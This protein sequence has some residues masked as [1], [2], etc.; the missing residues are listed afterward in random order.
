MAAFA[1][2]ESRHSVQ[3]D[4]IDEA[5]MRRG[6][7]VKRK[8]GS[9]GSQLRP[10]RPLREQLTLCSATNN[11]FSLHFDC[12]F[13]PIHFEL[14]FLVTLFLC[15]VIISSIL[16]FYFEHILMSFALVGTCL[17]PA[18]SCG[19]STRSISPQRD[20]TIF[21]IDFGLQFLWPIYCCTKSI[22]RHTR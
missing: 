22:E 17:M 7:R 6:G 16:I 21:K 19:E 5:R 2:P 20:F 1:G 18:S 14:Q 15:V 4:E 11:N 12:T 8:K 13:Y 3:T 9:E 10:L